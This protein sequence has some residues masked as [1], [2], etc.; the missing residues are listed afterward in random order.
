MKDIVNKTDIGKLTKMDGIFASINKKYG[1]PPN[2]KREQGFV[3][4]SRIILEQQVSLSSANA[5]FNK[6][7]DYVPEFTPGEIL[8]LSDAE[9]R[10]CQISRQ[11]T[12]YLRALASAVI[13]KRIVFDSFDGLE[14]TEIRK[15]LT[16]IKGIGEWTADIYLMF[17]LQE[18]DIFPF[19]DIAV[20]NAA[21]ELISAGTKEE[22]M[23]LA[24]KWKPFRSLAAYYF[25]H[26][27]LRI[28]NRSS[29]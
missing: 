9:M 27:Y 12:V 20:M 24:E 15:Q 26:Y 13:D 6:L 8:K 4:L 18:K 25:W 23:P 7:N 22:I 11:K 5:H 28:R 19:G 16:N 21:K 10:N 3:S 14:R 29:C 2:W 17:C 1:N